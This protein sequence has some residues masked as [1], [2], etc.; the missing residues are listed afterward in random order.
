[1]V[2]MFDYIQGFCLSFFILELFARFI[3]SPNFVK[4]FKEIINLLDI[5]LCI[6]GIVDFFIE[7]DGNIIDIFATLR[8]FSLIRLFRHFDGLRLLACVIKASAKEIFYLILYVL[9]AVL[10]YS[11]LIFLGEK[12]D[13][14]N[15]TMFT[16][17]P[18]TFW[19]VIVTLT[20]V[21][22][23]LLSKKI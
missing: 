4:F 20:T 10:F 7:N 22:K 19:Y 13:N 5:A 2:N 16:S 17:I 6:I 9:L 8:I 11:S 23:S 15:E 18:G 12:L 1:M 14:S 3:A 21:G